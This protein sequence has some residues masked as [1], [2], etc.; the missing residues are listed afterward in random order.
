[1][2]IRA[3]YPGR[4]VKCGGRINP[5]DQI[6]WDPNTKA[7]EHAECPEQ[8]EEPTATKTYNIGG[9]TRPTYSE[10]YI[11]STPRARSRYNEYGLRRDYCP[12][13]DA[14]ETDGKGNLAQAESLA[15]IQHWEA[16]LC[17]RKCLQCGTRYHCYG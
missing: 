4:C 6:H 17:L 16:R 7:T 3:R 8:I 12:G 5:G 13:C 2:T 11:L 9:G 10:R 15:D 1:M 14:P